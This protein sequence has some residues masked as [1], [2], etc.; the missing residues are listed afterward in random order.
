MMAGAIRAERAVDRDPYHIHLPS[1]REDY[2]HAARRLE[3]PQ[4]RSPSYRLAF[5]DPEFLLREELRPVRLQLELLKPELILQEHDI[6]S[7]IVVFGSSR[8]PAPEE[9]ARALERAERACRERPDD[10]RAAAELRRARHRVERVRWYEEAR[11][12]ARLVSQA[13]QQDGPRRF[14]VVTGGGPGIME[15]ANRGAAEIG[16]KSIGLNITL[17]HEQ[18]PNRWIT[19]ELCFQFH[20]FALRKMHFLLRARALVIFPGG[21]GTLDELFE[22][23]CLIQTRKARRI[24]VLL[25]DRAYWRRVIDFDVLVEEGM[26]DPEDTEIFR[27]VESAAEAWSIIRRHYGMDGEDAATEE[28]AG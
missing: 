13:G 15:A 21:F 18:M 6:E 25:F 5:A 19:P 12:F 1:A 9:A 10:P 28:A 27:Y 3:T 16:A 26:I 8:I 17:P 11:T 24:P 20:Y 2:E 7:T 23:L 4:T 22:T 14:V